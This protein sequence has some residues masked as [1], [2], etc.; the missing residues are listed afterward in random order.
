M[1]GDTLQIVKGSSVV[2]TVDEWFV[3]APPKGGS[4]HRRAGRSALACA[5]AW[6]NDG[7][8]RVPAEIAV[9]LASHP[10]TADARVEWAEPER[11][12]RFDRLRGEPRN[13]DVVALARSRH[14]AIAVS[15]EA[16]ADEPF[17][18]PVQQVLDAADARLAAGGRTNARVRAEQLAAALFS[19]PW[20]GAPLGAL[21]YQLLTAAAG[22]LAFARDVQATRAVLM[23]HEFVTPATD[24]ARHAANTADLDAFWAALTGCLGATLASGVLGGPVTVPGAPLFGNPVPLYVGKAHRVTRAVAASA[25]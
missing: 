18:R 3:A 19:P 22:A 10:D 6:C 4:R 17:D 9:L 2:A 7:R 12:V 20:N 23:V 8:P 1:I 14:G 25:V 11:R 21:R 15:V 16:K 13:A 24:D 5:E